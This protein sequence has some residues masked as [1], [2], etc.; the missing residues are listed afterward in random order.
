MT[1]HLR[2]EKEHN[3]FYCGTTGTFTLTRGDFL[4]RTIHEMLPNDGQ[5]YCKLN[6]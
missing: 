2:K 3:K 1:E 6:L 5:T 4:K